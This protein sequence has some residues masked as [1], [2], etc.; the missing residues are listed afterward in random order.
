MTLPPSLKSVKVVDNNDDLESED[1]ND[2]EAPEAEEVGANTDSCSA[3]PLKPSDFTT[4]DNTPNESAGTAVDVPCDVEFGL[5]SQDCDIDSGRGAEDVTDAK[6]R[7]G[8]E[9]ERSRTGSRGSGR[10]WDRVVEELGAANDKEDLADV[11]EHKQSLLGGPR[12]ECGERNRGIRF[13]LNGKQNGH[14]ADEGALAALGGV[15]EQGS[16]SEDSDASIQDNQESKPMD[17]SEGAAAVVV[18]RAIAE[19]SISAGKREKR[20]SLGARGSKTL[21]RTR[22]EP[23]LLSRYAFA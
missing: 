13:I 16:G 14:A 10:H 22:G 15:R 6:P 7:P 11:E 1:D 12:G 23:L 3:T 4:P 21:A 18:V 19:K 20:R 2:S 5:E 9:W 17:A 8:M